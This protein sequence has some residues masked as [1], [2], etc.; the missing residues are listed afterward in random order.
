MADETLHNILVRDF[1]QT[2]KDKVQKAADEDG[3]S[4]Q[5]FCKAAI[6]KKAG[7]KDPDEAALPPGKKERRRKLPP[8]KETPGKRK[9]R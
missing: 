1:T 4:V 5:V 7:V 3:R 9:A 6:L 2:E 8:N